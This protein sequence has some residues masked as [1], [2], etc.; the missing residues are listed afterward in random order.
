MQNTYRTGR[1][2]H[3]TQL[4]MRVNSI[5]WY[6]RASL[7]LRLSRSQVVSMEGWS[8]YR[9]VLPVWDHEPWY[10]RGGPFIDMVLTGGSNGLNREV[11]SLWRFTVVSVQ[12]C[13]TTRNWLI[14]EAR[15]N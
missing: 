12:K 7:A 1:S 2:V 3:I 14:K 11:V 6:S 5:F 10:Y 8:L 9:G 4:V 15:V 13:G